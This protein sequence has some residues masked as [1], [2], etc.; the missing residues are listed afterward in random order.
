MSRSGIC[1]IFFDDCV[2]MAL[3]VN[4]Q[5]WFVSELLHWILLFAIS[6]NLRFDHCARIHPFVWCIV[7]DVVARARRVVPVRRAS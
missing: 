6:F 4:D 1:V 2:C 5:H 7:E 3:D